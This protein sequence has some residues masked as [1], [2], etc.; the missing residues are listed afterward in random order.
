MHIQIRRHL[1]ST[2][3]ALAFAMLPT[4]L[5]LSAGAQAPYKFANTNQARAQAADRAHDYSAAM[6]WWLK[7]LQEGSGLS[8]GPEEE[9]DSRG[10]AQYRIG[11]YYELGLGVTQNY[12]TAARWYQQAIGNNNEW[13]T[14]RLGGASFFINRQASDFTK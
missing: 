9:L 10:Y 5:V 3:R 13:A 12:S 2:Y 14:A 11:Y 6:Q 1:V 7:E 4:F 8:Q